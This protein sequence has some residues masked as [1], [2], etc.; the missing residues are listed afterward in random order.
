MQ[1]VDNWGMSVSILL[2]INFFLIP[3]DIDGDHEYINAIGVENL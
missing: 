1:R 2:V 3:S